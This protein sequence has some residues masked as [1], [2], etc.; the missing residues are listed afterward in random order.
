MARKKYKNSLHDL[1]NQLM[2]APILFRNS[3]C[4][5]CGISVPTYYRLLR[6]EVVRD[7]ANPPKP[8]L[9]NA[10]LEK[11][12]KNGEEILR[13]VLNNFNRIKKNPKN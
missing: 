5:D 2:K 6:P 7:E 10:D 8:K 4:K 12:L 13:K 1:H 3:V 11:I 9:S